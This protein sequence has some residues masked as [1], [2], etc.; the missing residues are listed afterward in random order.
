MAPRAFLEITSR[1]STGRIII[2]LFY[3]KAPK[4][5][6]NFR[7]LCTGEKGTS[8]SGNRLC[9]QGTYLD[10][11]VAPEFIV[12]GGRIGQG[13][14]ESIYGTE[15][16]DEGLGETKLDRA[17]FVCM[18]NCG[19]NTNG[20]QFF[21]TLCPTPWLEKSTT[22]IGRV[23]SGYDVVEQLQYV[24]VDY[25]DHPL[26]REEVIITRCGQLEA[27]RKAKATTI[28]TTTTT[29]PNPAVHTKRASEI[30]HS[31]RPPRNNDARRRSRSPPY[32]DRDTKPLRQEASHRPGRD[33]AHTSQPPRESDEGLIVKG[34][35]RVKYREDG[36][37]DRKHRYRGDRRRGEP[38]YGRLN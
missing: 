16:E 37:R 38:D 30:Q 32:R 1:A 28:T 17:G 15:F 2:E 35:G 11:I 23:V 14:G 36:D 27:R 9:Y 8:P 4:A 18:A 5:C 7:C 29:A 13:V 26:Q 3:D 6:E 19:P 31:R 24:I 10:R 20:S 25:D 34:R 33:T 22:V 12:Q 21:I